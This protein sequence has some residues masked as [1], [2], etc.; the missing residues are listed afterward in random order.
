L[1]SVYKDVEM[2]VDIFLLLEFKVYLSFPLEGENDPLFTKFG[3][4]IDYSYAPLEE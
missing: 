4:R 2:M 3:D 1:G